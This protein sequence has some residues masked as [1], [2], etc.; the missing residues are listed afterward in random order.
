MLNLVTMWIFERTPHKCMEIMDPKLSNCY[1]EMYAIGSSL[2]FLVQIG[3]FGIPYFYAFATDSYETS[4]KAEEAIARCIFQINL[5]RMCM[6]TVGTISCWKRISNWYIVFSL[7][8]SVQDWK[9]GDRVL[10]KWQ[11]CKF[12]PAKIT[13]CLSDGKNLLNT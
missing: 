12:Y 10:A 2:Y 3:K 7:Y 11:D 8:M 6:Y 13:K 4:Q 5:F 1:K 9:T